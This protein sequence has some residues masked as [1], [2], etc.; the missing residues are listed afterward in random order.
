[1]IDKNKTSE[2][3]QKEIDNI[4]DEDISDE[5][6]FEDDKDKLNFIMKVYA[7]FGGQLSFTV[8]VI[9]LFQIP[10]LKKWM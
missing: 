7:I 2:D 8:V 1:M 3:I 9:S 5:V 4:D 6:K 10:S